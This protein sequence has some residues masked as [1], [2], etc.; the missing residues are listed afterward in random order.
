MKIER[1]PLVLLV[2]LIRYGRLTDG[3]AA[4]IL[5]GGERA[6]RRSKEKL[7]KIPGIYTTDG[8]DMATMNYIIQN[9]IYTFYTGIV[10]KQMRLFDMKNR[11]VPT[12]QIPSSLE[13]LTEFFQ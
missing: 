11:E 13:A 9:R 4:R 1:G 7:F 8:R 10:H 5:E 3:E 2:A 12:T 6:V